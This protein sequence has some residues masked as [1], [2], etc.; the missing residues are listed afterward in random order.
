[1]R[2]KWPMCPKSVKNSELEQ[3][4]WPVPRRAV[5][6]GRPWQ[7]K[8]KRAKPGGCLT[9]HQLQETENYQARTDITRKWGE[10]I[11]LSEHINDNSNANVQEQKTANNQDCSK[12]SAA[13]V[14]FQ[15]HFRMTNFINVTKVARWQRTAARSTLTQTGPSWDPANFH[16]WVSATIVREFLTHFQESSVKLA[17]PANW[18]E[19]LE[20]P[21]W[22]C[23]RQWSVTMAELR[24]T[25]RHP[26]L[27]KQTAWSW[28]DH[29]H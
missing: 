1:M 25:E 24:Q 17:V 19:L 29:R 3:A 18:P 27:K 14:T 28:A 12:I 10:V 23:C 9:P 11:Y 5:K 16:L 22:N 7:A 21:C 15:A 20:R 4:V 13:S 26:E 6:M 8:T 2:E